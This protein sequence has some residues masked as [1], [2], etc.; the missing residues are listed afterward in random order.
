VRLESI[1]PGPARH[2]LLPI[3]LLADD[4]APDYVDDGDLW[5]FGRGAVEGVVLTVPADEDGTV[6]LRNV[7]VREESQG[8]GVGLAMVSAVL[9]ALRARGWRRA[10]V[11]TG[12]A[13]PLTYVFYQ[14][15]GFRPHHVERDVFTRERGYDPEKLREDNGLTHLDRLWFDQAL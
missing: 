6:E 5:A 1:P 4:V 14:R 9:G 8:R 11:G 7:A 15:C 13:D 2:A 12:T 3:L 10:V